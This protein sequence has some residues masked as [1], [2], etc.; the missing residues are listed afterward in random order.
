MTYDEACTITMD[1]RTR[2]DA[3]F[4]S[5]DKAQIE[6]LYF[7]VMA[8]TFRPTSCQTCYHDALIEIYLY[9]KN[10]KTMAVK[11]NYRLRAGFIINNPLFHAGKIYTNDNITDEVAAEYLELYPA[12]A[13][14]FQAI[15]SEPKNA[16]KAITG[17]KNKKPNK[18]KA[19]T[20]KAV[21]GKNKSK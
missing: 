15:P 4:S 9:L 11:S 19:G 2:Y 8:K 3:P 12:M 6:V 18:V 5:H 13:E 17:V 16:Q 21:K 7:E 20:N 10:N 1:L 14:M